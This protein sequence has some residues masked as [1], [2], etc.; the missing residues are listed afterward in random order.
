MNLDKTRIPRDSLAISLPQRYAFLHGEAGESPAS[1]DMLKIVKDTDPRMRKKCEP[2]AVPLNEENDALIHEMM[3]YIKDSQD[4]AFREKHPSVR[5]GVG[6]AA[7]QIGKCLRMLVIYYP[8]GDKYP[9]VELALAN[10]RIITNSIR[11]AYLQSGEGCL[12]VDAD[13]P[14]HVI[15][16]FKIKVRAYDALA[17]QDVEIVA[18]GYDAIVLQ[19]EIDHLD[20]ILFYDRIPKDNPFAEPPNS[21]AI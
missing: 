14:G 4:P 16:D 15:R 9:P 8:R 6:L 3:R 21:E 11:K 5:E 7:P 17:K 1:I 19:H 2:V 18:R 20:G 12:S 13:H 10:P